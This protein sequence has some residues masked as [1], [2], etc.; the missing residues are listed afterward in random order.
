[1]PPPFELPSSKAG[2]GH[3]RGG[4]HIRRANAKTPI[5]ASAGP[6]LAFF[7]DRTQAGSLL[8]DR[9]RRY[10]GQR[11]V[12]VLGLA[13]GGVPVA[14][15]V[16]RRLKAPLD[17]LVVRKLGVPGNEELAFGAIAPGGVRWLDRARMRRLAL[18]TAEVDAVTAA[19]GRELERRI[20][21]YHT[22]RPDNAW[23]DLTI[24]LV[25]DGVA[26]GATVLAA[27]AALRRSGVARV[28]VA[29]PTI[30]PAAWRRLQAKADE[31]VAVLVPDEFEWV[32]QWFGNFR[33]VTDEEVMR[34]LQAKARGRRHRVT[35][36]RRRV[37]AG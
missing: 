3:R 9:L 2:R 26:T 10:A 36:G 25:D 21:C 5:V 23:K 1:M 15:A 37:A 32:G 27:L 8:A 29:A 4:R 17:L 34:A 28:I 7:R 11:D 24:I 12:L 31:V 20:L 22:G 35:A 19:E 33:P 30:A 18:T 16:A 6:R 13:R 14:A